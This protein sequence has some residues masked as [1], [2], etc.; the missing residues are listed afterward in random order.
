M[1][2][3]TGLDIAHDPLATTLFESLTS[4]P[5]GS[6]MY[7]QSSGGTAVALARIPKNIRCQK[8]AKRLMLP[9]QDGRISLRTPDQEIGLI[10]SRAA[11]RIDT[12]GQSPLQ[13]IP[14]SANAL[15]NIQRALNALLRPFLGQWGRDLHV[16][17]S[18]Q[19]AKQISNHCSQRQIVESI[20][21]IVRNW[22]LSGPSPF[23]ISLGPI[24]D[25]MSLFHPNTVNVETQE[26]P[27]STDHRLLIRAKSSISIAI[28]R[29]P[30]KMLVTYSCS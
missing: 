11:D 1:G 18:R 4:R 9:P 2:I 22:S 7:E 12:H 13:A 20:T 27:E 26:C 29:S 17:T 10:H 3:I 15:G 8:D 25:K 24:D 16:L 6:L 21:Q 28:T 14:R 19:L 30:S 23:P 5:Q